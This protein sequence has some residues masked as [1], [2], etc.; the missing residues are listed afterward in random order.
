MRYK[1]ILEEHISKGSRNGYG[2]G[3]CLHLRIE[4]TGG[5]LDNADCLVGDGNL[6]DI[7]SVGRDHSVQAK[8]EVLGVHVQSE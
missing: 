8:L 4:D 1:K 2:S 7:A 5:G 6:E 3:Y